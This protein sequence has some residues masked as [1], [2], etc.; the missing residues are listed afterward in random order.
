MK[1]G[2]VYWVENE[3]STGS[4]QRG[5]RPAIIV[6]NDYGNKFGSVVEIVYLTTAKKRDLPTHVEL[7]IDSLRR[8]ST[9]L[10]E[11]ICS[12]SKDKIKDFIGTVGDRDMLR[13]NKAMLI[14]LG[15][16]E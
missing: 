2:D 10:C 5:T 15:I 3:W 12:I 11:Q 4:E 8:S 16:I 14:S 9:A 13:I 6:S 1:R 7:Y